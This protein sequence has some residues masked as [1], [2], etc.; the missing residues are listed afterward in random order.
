MATQTIRD[1]LWLWGMK[2]NILQESSEKHADLFGESKMTVEDAIHK[3]GVRNVLMAG[4]LPLDRSALDAM[5]S[6]QRIIC[7]WSM[8]TDDRLDPEG[9]NEKLLMAKKLAAQD[10]RIEAYL[11]DDFS[12]VGMDLG[13]GAE[14]FRQLQIANWVHGPQ[15]PLGGTLYTMNL[16]R[17]GLAATLPYLS[18]INFSHWQFTDVD[19]YPQALDRLDQFTGS[20]PVLFSEYFFDFDKDQ[21]I[22]RE[23]MQR[24]LDLAEALLREQR[25]VGINICGTCMMDLDWPAVHCFHD[26]LDRVGDTAI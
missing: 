14:H 26:W 11:I 22:T 3:T 15:L 24:H 18:F 21:H 5:P 16:D 1:R 12:S 10:T 23:T 17:P 6:A 9:A 19:A 25:V 8:H 4:N 2:V 7:K 13:A 20:K